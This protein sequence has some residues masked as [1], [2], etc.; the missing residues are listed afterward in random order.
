MAPFILYAAADL[1]NAKVNLELA[2]PSH[3]TM[4]E[5]THHVHAVFAAECAALFEGMG[6]QRWRCPRQAA[7]FRHFS[8]SALQ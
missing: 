5:L 3:P 8:H 4:G 7:A 1:Y 2:F 6:G